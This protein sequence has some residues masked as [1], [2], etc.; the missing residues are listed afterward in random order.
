MLDLLACWVS[1][2]DCRVRSKSLFGKS[3]GTCDYNK[4]LGGNTQHLAIRILQLRG[5]S[6]IILSTT[7]CSQ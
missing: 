6:A 1:Y 5:R 4:G 3:S 7:Q 2:P